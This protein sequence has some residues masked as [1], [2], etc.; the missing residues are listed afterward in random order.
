MTAIYL[1]VA[2]AIVAVVG[3]G[4]LY[5]LINSWHGTQ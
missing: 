4:L 1:I 5:W 3:C 2:L